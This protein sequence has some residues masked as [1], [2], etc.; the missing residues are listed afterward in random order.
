MKKLSLYLALIASMMALEKSRSKVLK[1][2]L[3]VNNNK[4]SKV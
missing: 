2:L 1:E 4:R 3:P